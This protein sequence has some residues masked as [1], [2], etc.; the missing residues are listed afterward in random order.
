[1]GLFGF[2]MSAGQVAYLRARR[3]PG[4]RQRPESIGTARIVSGN[5]C[6]LQAISCRDQVEAW[7]QHASTAGIRTSQSGEPGDGYWR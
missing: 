7:L 2:A 1:M 5:R 4:F 6:A 3:R